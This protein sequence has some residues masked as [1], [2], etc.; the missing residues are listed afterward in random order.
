MTMMQWTRPWRSGMRAWETK[1]IWIWPMWILR[2]C[3]LCRLVVSISEYILEVCIDL[4]T[5][6]VLIKVYSLSFSNQQTNQTTTMATWS[7]SNSLKS[8]PRSTVTSKTSEP[9][10][11]ASRITCGRTSITRRSCMLRTLAC[12]AMWAFWTWVVGLYCSVFIGNLLYFATLP[13]SACL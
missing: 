13:Y 1:D 6:L 10:S 5:H 2:R 8:L 3:R 12:R 7:N 9:S 11:W 4:V